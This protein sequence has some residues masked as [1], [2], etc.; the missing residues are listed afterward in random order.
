MYT[1]DKVF[2][3]YGSGI[4]RTTKKLVHQRETIRSSS[5]FLQLRPLS[6]WELLLKVIICSLRAIPY[7]MENYFYT[8]GDLP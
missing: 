4:A 8:L 5:C 3:I 6:K 1:A 7:G 2:N